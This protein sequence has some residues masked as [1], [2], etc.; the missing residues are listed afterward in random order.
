MTRASIWDI[1]DLRGGAPASPRK[2]GGAAQPP[3]IG[4]PRLARSGQAGG[5][6][7]AIGRLALRERPPLQAALY[8][9]LQQLARGHGE[10]AGYL[11]PGRFAEQPSCSS[12]SRPR[13]LRTNELGSRPQ[14]PSSIAAG[15]SASA[16]RAS[17]SHTNRSNSALRGGAGSS[18]RGGQ[19]RAASCIECPGQQQAARLGVDRVGSAATS[20]PPRSAQAA[21]RG[22]HRENPALASSPLR[23]SAQVHGSIRAA[24]GTAPAL[25]EDLGAPVRVAHTEE[26]PERCCSTSSAPSDSHRTRL[27]ASGRVTPSKAQRLRAS[28]LVQ[29][30]P[31]CAS[32]ELV[33]Y[34]EPASGSTSQ[35]LP[36]LGL[37]QPS[38]RAEV[39][40]K[41]SQADPYLPPTLPNARAQ[42]AADTR[43][44]SLRPQQAGAAPT[45]GSELEWGSLTDASRQALK[46]W[47]AGQLGGR[48]CMLILEHGAGADSPP[49]AS[50]S[51]KNSELCGGVLL[52]MLSGLHSEVAVL[53]GG[54]G[55][56]LFSEVFSKTPQQVLDEALTAAMEQVGDS[57]IVNTTDLSV[58]QGNLALRRR[59]MKAKFN[60]TGCD[61]AT[62]HNRGELRAGDEYTRVQV[63]LELLR[64]HA[65]GNRG[66]GHSG[67][68]SS[69]AAP[70]RDR[71][72]GK[73]AKETGE[74]SWHDGGVLRELGKEEAELENDSKDMS[75]EALRVQNQAIED[76]VMRLVKQRDELKQAMK[77]AE[78]RDSYAILGLEGPHVSDDLV[79]KAYRN[80]ARREHPDKAG[81]A[82]KKRFQAIQQAYTNIQRQR[83]EGGACTACPNESAGIKL[84]KEEQPYAAVGEAAEYA[85]QARDL[86][87]QVAMCAHRAI[88]GNEEGSEVQ[89]QPKRRALR[90]LRDLTQHGAAE[91][92]VAAG[93]LRSLST[94][95]CGVVRCL[96]STMEEHSE[97]A[98][99]TVAGIGLNDRAVILDDAGR[100]AVNS[101]DLLEKISDATEG[102]LQKVEKASPE[103]SSDQ[104]APSRGARSD[105]AGKLMKLGVRLLTESLA[106]TAAVARRAADEA[107]GGAMKALELS[108][109]LAALDIEV[110]KEK[111]K[112][113]ARQHSFNEDEAVPAGDM[114]KPSPPSE[115][116]DKADG[117][118]RGNRPVEAPSQSP[119]NEQDTAVQSSPRDQLKSAAQR[120]K[121]RHIALR[122]KNLRFLSSLNE[123]AMKLQ[124]RL[125]AMLEHNDGSLLPK[126]TVPQKRQAFDL[127]AQLLDFAVAE[128][129]RLA[130]HPS[131][132]PARVLDKAL[133]FALALEHS[134]AIAVP[135]DSRTQAMKLAALL[136]LDLLCQILDG[137]FRRQLIA[138][139]TR[140]RTD[141]APLGGGGYVSSGY[142]RNRSSSRTQSA[143]SMMSWD[144]AAHGCCTRI[145]YGLRASTASA[146]EGEELA[147]AG[148]AQ[149]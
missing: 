65:E 113:A 75:L 90:I 134:Q 62:P 88:K 15:R 29:S 11:W 104:P 99:M 19:P 42:R 126:V 31:L 78:E 27:N 81:F 143:G 34:V 23:R 74:R 38:G 53:T 86:A 132:T 73:A 49:V 69:S 71:D 139:G 60:S 20:S 25:V 144:E 110:R 101:A 22:V 95:V 39:L 80:L 84:G 131:A 114:P 70:A 119:Q 141:P 50:A 63:W 112:E 128:C 136:D 12:S 46:Q 111:E 24:D 108:Q 130:A 51:N 64:M 33:A 41:W 83:K 87:D 79:K 48:H 1:R 121:E 66:D 109:G 55:S 40:Q 94:A 125:R 17:P 98:S 44:S 124:G 117:Q 96:E 85:R 30:G 26:L 21:R 37:L 47:V 43:G 148:A 3:P 18:R 107:I 4:S 61:S 129:A 127:V 103:G 72:K 118:G 138:V 7:S 140:R 142:S 68:S 133:A 82:N 2:H 100:S 116:K 115:T 57:R 122:V 67:T 13:K 76:Y 92:R 91:L 137:P 89:A 28:S 135:T 58:E 59:A 56:W 149:P 52:N 106:R 145:V 93:H 6:L 45:E 10:G 36:G 32:G 146:P 77:A 120:V 54:Q 105:E 102:T 16:P 14:S 8:G 97:L 147:T 123:E 35:A 9:H 5:R